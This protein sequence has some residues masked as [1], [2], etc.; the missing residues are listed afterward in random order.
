MLYMPIVKL[1]YEENGLDNF[2]LFLLHGIYSLVIA[3]LEIPSGYAADIWGRKNALIMGTTFGSIGFAIY[4]FTYGFW[5]FLLAELALGIGQSFI[6]G[7]DSAMLYDTLLD[8]KK[9]KQYLKYEGRISATG[10]FAESIAGILGA[11]L[12]VVSARTPYYYQ[13]AVTILGIPAAILL[14]SPVSH[15]KIIRG[16]FRYIFN[17]V[18]YAL[19]ENKPLRNAIMLSSVIGFSTLTMAWFA[20][21]YFFTTGLPRAQY[22][23]IW[24]LLNL[25]V[26]LGSVFAYRIEKKLGV[27]LTV[28]LIITGIAGGYFLQGFFIAIWAISL[29]FVF[30]FIRGIATP[31]LKNYINLNTVS[32]TRAT[33]LSVR[34]LIIRI[35]FSVAGPF[36]GWMTD[37]IS[38]GMALIM[39]GTFIFILGGI[40]SVKVIHTSGR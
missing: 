6:S 3:L 9:E 24:T 38:L 10:N 32:D 12:A 39:A 7:S 33:V 30:Y 27:K 31:V 35:I 36:L 23:I 22:G 15:R 26:G 37:R 2:Q 40:A 11:L 18:K 5:G 34:S 17:V 14:S 1:F 20:Q 21:I 16:N 28:I 29:L 25:T 19:V 4:S 13:T 8:M